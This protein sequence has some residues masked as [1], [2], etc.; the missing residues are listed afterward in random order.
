VRNV[1]IGGATDI[2][3]YRAEGVENLEYPVPDPEPI[4]KVLHGAREDER[5]TILHVD[6]ATPSIV[7]ETI[8]P[9]T[10]ITTTLVETLSVAGSMLSATIDGLALSTWRIVSLSS[11]RAPWSTLAIGSGSGTGYSRFST[12]SAR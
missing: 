8:E 11:S 1:R 4:A 10:E 2:Y 5:L 3:T 12:P 6:N 7:A 9:A